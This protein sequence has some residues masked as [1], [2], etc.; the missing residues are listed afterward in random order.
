L[1]I[2][3]ND[4]DLAEKLFSKYGTLVVFLSRM[5]PVLRTFISFPAGIARMNQTTF[6]VYTFA[7]S[8]LWSIVLTYVGVAAGVNWGILSPLFR[9]FDWIIVLCGIFLVVWWI[10]RHSKQ[11]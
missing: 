9:K 8:A 7:G 10:R 5:L 1:F 6:L 2:A 11:R 3:K 4:L